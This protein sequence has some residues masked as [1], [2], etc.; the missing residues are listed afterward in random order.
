MNRITKILITLAAFSITVILAQE[1]LAAGFSQGN[2]LQ[3]QRITGN[4]TLFCQGAQPGQQIKH[5]RCDADLWTP[6]LKD[7]FVG[8]V[9][10]ADTVTLN[11]LR[12]DGSQ[13]SKD[14]KYDGQTGQSKSA[15][16]L[17]IWTVTQK[18]LLL[19]GANQIHFSLSKDNQTVT[20]GDFTATVTR[21]PTAVCP[22][23][24]ENVFGTQCDYP[25]SACDRYFERFD[26][27]Q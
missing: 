27:C 6:G 3:V 24:S 22:S 15:F 23:A 14:S 11:S 17:G 26:Y 9:V 12:A 18:P 25:Q 8:P 19:E 4:L 7:Y 13:K 21:Q 2:D 1:S 16:N 5:V 20:E 10:D